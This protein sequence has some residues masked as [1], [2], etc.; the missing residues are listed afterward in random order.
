[1]SVEHTNRDSFDIRFQR[2]IEPGVIR[3]FDF[4]IM[5]ES[6]KGKGK[7]V[8]KAIRVVSMRDDEFI[9]DK[10]DYEEQLKP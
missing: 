8:K 7:G 1:M 9:L 5:T 3:I 4:H 2:L 10:C 6:K